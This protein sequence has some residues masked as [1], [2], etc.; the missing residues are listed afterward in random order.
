MAKEKNVPVGL[1][2]Y[3][4]KRYEIYQ[5]N[6]L[7]FVGHKL[8]IPRKEQAFALQRLHAGHQGIENTKALAREYMYWPGINRDIEETVKACKVC[9]RYRKLNTKEP[10]KQ[11]YIPWVKIGADIFQFGSKDYLVVI[12]YYFKFP[13]MARLRS[14]T[15]SSVV[16]ATKTIFAR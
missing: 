8:I 11:H 9:Q 5:E 16:Q 1:I 2:P 4:E 6:D 14:K 13:E 12:D 3:Y 7:L 15:A 10:I